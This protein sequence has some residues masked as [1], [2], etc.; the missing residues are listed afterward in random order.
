[1]K[2]WALVVAGLYSLILV[3]FTVPVILL[4]MAPKVTAEEALDSYAHWQYWLGLGVMAVSQFALLSVPVR[5]AAR[6]P[7]TRSALWPTLL[8]GGLMAAGLVIGAGYSLLEFC[9][10]DRAVPAL[11]RVFP[12][13]LALLT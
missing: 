4:A 13:G 7:I 6:R 1:M 11:L 10:R 9:V 3:I 8:A 5:I 2:R 12:L